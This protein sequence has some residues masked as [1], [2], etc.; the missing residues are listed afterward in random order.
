MNEGLLIAILV[1]VAVSTGLQAAALMGAAR[2]VKRLE[3]RL[4][5]A[6]QELRALRPRLERL[7][8]VVDNLADWTEGAAEHIP[9]IAA[10][11][12][13]TMDQIRGVAKLGAMVLVKPLR[14]L[15]AAWALWKGVSGGVA[16]LRARREER[17]LR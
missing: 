2:A 7:G 1:L 16:A 4:D 10:D 6:E 11:I 12:E 14:P 17:L 5:G 8:T 3:R 9:R 15:G 13:H